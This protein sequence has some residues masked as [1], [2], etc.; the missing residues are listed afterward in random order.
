MPRAAVEARVESHSLKSFDR[1]RAPKTGQHQSTQSVPAVSCHLELPN[2]SRMSNYAWGPQ[3]TT[4][5]WQQVS[6]SVEHLGVNILSHWVPESGVQ[7][8]WVASSATHIHLFLW[9]IF[10]EDSLCAW[11]RAKR[12]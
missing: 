3:L 12:W 6:L 2:T 7:Q 10:I 8:V 4:G 9:E 5:D 11:C 1:F